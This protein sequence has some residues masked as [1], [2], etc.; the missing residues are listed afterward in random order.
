[1]N[2]LLIANGEPPSP[3]LFY[4]LCHT[5]SAL[6]AVDGGLATCLE[7]GRSPSLVI[8]DFDSASEATLLSLEE[9]E[10]IH[11]PDQNYTDL[12][13]ALA[14]VFKR[15]N[16]SHV[17][18][19]GALGRR[20]DH[21]LTNICLLCRYPGKVSYETDSEVCF[22]LL[23]ESQVECKQDQTLSLIPVG[24][25]VTGVTTRGLKWE[26]EE[27]TLN[28]E[29]VCISNK[30]EQEQVT[31]RFKEGQLVICISKK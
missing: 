5:H 29:F 14:F 23:K 16:P 21:T 3:S 25:S 13:K 20:L 26:L 12:E 11:T 8:G 10:K 18:V 7:L 28:T 1:M 17:T 9:V 24:S 22:S 30:A 4:H 15:F 6:I 31:I 27:A 2:I 19:C